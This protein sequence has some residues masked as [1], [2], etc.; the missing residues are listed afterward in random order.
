MKV[1]GV[2]NIV[3]HKLFWN[4]HITHKLQAT[5]ETK[6]FCELSRTWSRQRNCVSYGLQFMNCLLYEAWITTLDIAVS[7]FPVRYLVYT[8]WWP[9]CGLVCVTCRLERLVD[10]LRRKINGVLVDEKP[11]TSEQSPTESL[12]ST[13]SSSSTTHSPQVTMSG[14]VTDLWRNYNV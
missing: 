5:Y 4:E 11:A 14:P 9:Y 8:L 6:C 10:V 7:W 2:G 3:E 1:I 13:V 12:V